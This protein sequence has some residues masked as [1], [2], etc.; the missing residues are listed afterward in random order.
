MEREFSLFLLFVI[1]QANAVCKTRRVLG[2]LLQY[3]KQPLKYHFKGL[4]FT[5][6]KS[7]T[8]ETSVLLDNFDTS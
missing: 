7:Y 2:L 8:P 5:L 6:K 3:G 4:F 1:C